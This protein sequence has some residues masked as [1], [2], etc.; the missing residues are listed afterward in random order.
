MTKKYVAIYGKNGRIV[1]V[2]ADSE[3][4][5]RQRIREQLDRRGRRQLLKRWQDDG[6]RLKTEEFCTHRRLR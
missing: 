1:S 5:A 2:I 3:K 4:E 6:E